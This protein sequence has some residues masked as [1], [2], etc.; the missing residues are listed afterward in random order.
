M[1]TKNNIIGPPSIFPHDHYKVIKDE[2]LALH[3]LRPQKLIFVIGPPGVGKTSLL[4]SFVR[5]VEGK[6]ISQVKWDLSKSDDEFLLPFLKG[7]QLGLGFTGSPIVDEGDATFVCFDPA[8]QLLE[9]KSGCSGL[10]S[11]RRLQRLLELANIIPVLFTDYVILDH[12]NNDPALNAASKILHFRRYRQH[13]PEE[14]KCFYRTVANLEIR[15][16]ISLMHHKKR[17]LELSL[18]SVGTMIRLILEA[19]RRARDAGRKFGEDELLQASQ[20][21]YQRRKLLE[22]IVS[23]EDR[24]DGKAAVQGIFSTAA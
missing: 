12:I 4:E 16:G 7:K 2:L 9:L 3:K 18:G 1:N 22:H 15:L 20:T 24:I 10:R 14:A 21:H 11:L 23:Y 17:L 13:E 5:T 8:D 19:T 6:G